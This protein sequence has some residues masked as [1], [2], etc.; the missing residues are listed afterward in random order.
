[1]TANPRPGRR[2]PVNWIGSEPNM[3][4]I[5]SRILKLCEQ[6][7]GKRPR[8]VIEYILKHG[9]VTTEELQ[10]LGYEHPPRAARDVREQGI[11]LETFR[12]ASKK[13]G[14]SI[15]AYRFGD[16]SKIVAGRIG[17][18]KAF[19]KQL[20]VALLDRYGNR[21]HFT[22]QVLPDTALTIDHRVPYEVAGDSGS[23][24]PDEFMLLD[25]S[26]QR[27]KSWSCEN[28][29]NWQSYKN[30]DICGTC[31]WAYPESY[32]HLA[33]LPLRR[34]DVSWHGDEIADFEGLANEAEE[35]GTSIQELI[36]QR[37]KQMLKR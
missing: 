18:R 29:E 26:S 35:L 19:P 30:P 21:D 33:L 17:G 34:L 8:T 31:Y 9:A 6:V 22:G 1:M 7:T 12:V 4:K 32:T 23:F 28:C 13:D 5:D 11:P 25:G 10:D 15:G 3:P 20:K 24:D 27:T 37:M 36:K 16:P 14:K 2:E